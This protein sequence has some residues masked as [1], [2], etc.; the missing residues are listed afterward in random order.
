V[1]AAT[2][3]LRHALDVA[4]L[5]RREVQHLPLGLVAESWDLFCPHGG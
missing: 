4:R 2:E 1:D 3:A 5:E